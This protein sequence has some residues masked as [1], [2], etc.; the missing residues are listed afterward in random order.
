MASGEVTLSIQ[1]DLAGHRMLQSAGERIALVR[2][3][4]GEPGFVVVAAV[5][6]PFGSTTKVLFFPNWQVYVMQGTVQPMIRVNMQL[7][8]DSTPGQ[9]YTFNGSGFTYEGRAYD[10]SL[11]GLR[12]TAANVALCAGL[13]QQMTVSNVQIFEAIHIAG[14][15]LNTT[16]Y[17]QPTDDV[18]VFLVKGVE[19]GDVLPASILW[20]ENG[21]GGLR[22]MAGFPVLIGAYLRVKMTDHVTIHLDDLQNCFLPGPLPER[23]FNF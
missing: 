7:T 19:S 15:P 2:V 11:F 16:G 10:P 20:R 5:F 1:V 22:K 14:S 8:Q 12:N 6:D 9:L 21:M 4:A 3:M 18:L 17:F 13:A 23:P